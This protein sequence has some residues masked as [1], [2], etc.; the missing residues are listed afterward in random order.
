[1]INIL[2]NPKAGT[3]FAE[4]VLET[5]QN[6]DRG[7]RREG[8]PPDIYSYEKSTL[9]KKLLKIS[10]KRTIHSPF[11]F[12]HIVLP[13]CISFY[14]K[15]GKTYAAPEGR[16][17][18]PST[19]ASWR[20][21]NV[22]LDTKIISQN[23]GALIIRVSPGEIG[24]VE[25]Q[26]VPVL[27]DVGTH[28]FNS[29]NVTFVK[30]KKVAES[31][32]FSHGPYHSVRVARGKYAKVWV[33]IE[34]EGTMSLT[35]RLLREGEHFIDSHYFKFDGLVQVDTPY[36]AHGSVHVIS[37]A[38]GSVAK[39][40][41]ENSARLLGQ[42]DHFVQSTQFEYKGT[43]S[44]ISNPCIVHGTIT[45]LR[46][47]LGV[48][49]LAWGEDNTPMFIDKPGL[50]EFDSPGFV[51]VEFKNAEER[52]I[53]LG[54]RKIVIVHTG[55]VGVTYDQGLLKILPHGRH[56]INNSAHIFHRFL[57][58][59]QK[60]IR[61]STL[62]AGEKEA[63]LLK[64]SGRQQGVSDSVIPGLR[65]PQRRALDPDSDLTICE[66]RDL[67]KVGMRADVFYSIDD[68]EKCINKIDS[69]EVEDLV[70]ETAL[71]TL[72][73]IIRSTALNQIAQSQQV[74]AGSVAGGVS[75]MSVP[76]G[77]GGENYCNNP[78][79]TVPMAV[80]FD[81]AHDE[82]LDK[83][84]DDFMQRYGVNIANIRIESFKI[85]DAELSEQI[86]KHALTTAQIENEMANL[87]GKSLIST[88]EG[89]TAAEVKMIS[90]ESQARALKTESDAWNQ[91][92]V[93]TAK[94]E[95]EALKI[96]E[97]A[98]AEVASEAILMEAKAQ[99]SHQHAKVRRMR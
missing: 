33:Q 52:L 98:K 29:G 86:S 85:M 24:F 74:S 19:E 28:V 55:Q 4:A 25:K 10:E 71:A 62:K 58:V 65:A 91:R 34:V 67:V 35:P 84:H 44:L 92:K 1:M 16:W 75:I 66:T 60:S 54:S 40:F 72:T 22:R 37:V 30:H 46:V 17:W 89:K 99:V 21:R 6:G 15:D 14:V 45:V 69:D 8:F 7:G 96:A 50:Y 70:R 81:K 36:I 53:S 63:R 48:V 9:M 94:A 76:Y 80:F 56:S 38:K 64:K 47:T 23:S 41:Q 88:T 13:G 5:N 51:F 93:D 95:A 97:R 3:K 12:G 18:L 27:L 78:A 42:G 11:P 61:L 68:P 73:N 2:T 31:A 20:N 59:Q 83:L 39:V 77:N 79:P 82:F 87:E 26:G 43:E 49:A 90:A 57:S 32:Y